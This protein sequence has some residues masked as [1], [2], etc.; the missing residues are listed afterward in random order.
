[1]DP[2][3]QVAH[4]SPRPNVDDRSWGLMLSDKSFYDFLTFCDSI[5]GE[6][7]DRRQRFG[8]V[9]V[10]FSL[11]K[12][13]G[14]SFGKNGFSWWSRSLRGFS[15]QKLA[16]QLVRWRREEVQVNFHDATRALHPKVKRWQESRF[17]LTNLHG[18]RHK[19]LTPGRSLFLSVI[20][21]LSIVFLL[22][23]IMMMIQNCWHTEF[24]VYEFD[25]SLVGQL[26]NFLCSSF[27][28]GDSD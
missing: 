23:F 10:L 27:V 13:R 14:K 5:D 9:K 7:S 21:V 20:I 1:M 19:W 8:V 28:R 6:Q 25:S 4:S 24:C 2:G 18:S 12:K 15:G 17:T 11:D 16:R 26:I 22:H 3:N